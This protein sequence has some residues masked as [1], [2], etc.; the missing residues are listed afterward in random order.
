MLQRLHGISGDV[1][2]LDVRRFENQP[3]LVFDPL[4]LETEL[5]APDTTR[6]V[7]ADLKAALRQHSV[8]EVWRSSPGTRHVGDGSQSS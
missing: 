6:T 8:R 7:A 2:R 5:A 3:R 1:N 4:L